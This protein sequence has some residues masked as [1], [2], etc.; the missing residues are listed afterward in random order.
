MHTGLCLILLPNGLFTY[1]M[2]GTEFECEVPDFGLYMIKSY[3]L[4]FGFYY[5]QICGF[6]FGLYGARQINNSLLP[7]VLHCRFWHD[8]RLGLIYSAGLQEYNN[9]VASI[10]PQGNGILLRPFQPRASTSTV[11]LAARGSLGL[12]AS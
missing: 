7:Q 12:T 5:N 4:T 11:N 1:T 6:G 3:S 10:F 2:L 8:R 9:G